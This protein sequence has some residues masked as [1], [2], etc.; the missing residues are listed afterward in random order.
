MPYDPN[1]FSDGIHNTP[2]GIKLRAWIALQQLV[3]VIEKKL[4]DG[5]WP[6]AVPPMPAQHPAFA[7]PP[8][9]IK[10]SCQAS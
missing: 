2:P 8:R 6:R 4:A 10:F 9:L 3:P 7:V 5:T 1:L